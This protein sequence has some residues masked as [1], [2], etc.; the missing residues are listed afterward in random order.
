MTRIATA[1]LALAG[2]GAFAD[3]PRRRF[4]AISFIDSLGTGLFLPLMVL[5]FTRSA[6]LTVGQ[7]ALGLTLAGIAALVATPAGGHL[8]DRYDPRLT[9]VLSYGIRAAVYAAYSVV[10]SIVAFIPLVCLAQ[11]SAQ[12]G[13]S[14]RTLVVA[15]MASEEER[16]RLLAGVSTIRNLGVGLG[17][18][19]AG[20]ALAGD[21]RTAYLA[22]VWINAAS[23]LLG[24]L[25]VWTMPATHPRRQ[26]RTEDRGTVRAVLRNR[27][28][29]SLASLNAVLLVNDA[30]LIVGV[31]IWLTTATDAPAALTGLLFTLNT[32]LVVLLQ[33][34]LSRSSKTLHGAGRAYLF[35]GAAFLLG[36]FLFV[37]AATDGRPLA[38][39][40]MIAGVT[41][42]TVAEIFSVA[43]GWSVSLGLAPLEQRGRYLAVF[44]LGEGVATSAGPAL[45]TLAV[46]QGGGP[47]WIALGAA[48]TVAGTVAWRLCRVR[49]DQ[50]PEP[51]A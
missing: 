23:Y 12:V 24:G 34:V 17:S 30:A 21:T 29:T 27:R 32:V 22:V 16:V 37:L 3:G 42:L 15:G 33:V 5:F 47:G 48:G 10:H 45:V 1:W 19:G 14:A 46:V 36:C 7:V 38:I 2:S 35:S 49:D 6:G 43:A 40:L 44:S 20:V 50:V 8:L 13:R 4:A 26:P 39:M 11:A 18:L 9:L 41:A 25:L 28:F 31:P 51:S